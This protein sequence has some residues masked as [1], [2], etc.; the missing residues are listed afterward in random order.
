MPRAE[1]RSPAAYEDLRSLDAPGF[2]WEFLSRNS[3]FRERPQEARTSRTSGSSQRRRTGWFRAAL[4]GAISQCREPSRAER[5]ALWTPAS[6]PSVI[7]MSPSR[8][9]SPP[10]TCR[11]MPY[12][13]GRPV[14]EDGP[15]RLIESARQSV[16]PAHP[17]TNWRANPL[18]RPAAR[19][20]VRDPRGR[21]TPALAR[22]NGPHARARSRDITR[23]ST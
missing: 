10:R 11:L 2:A 1:W 7:P 23:R 14:A 12:P 18:R 21:R 3:G 19:P 13:S 17:R 5:P 16:P 6:L 8:Q 4:G 9:I 20:V 15:E 22:L